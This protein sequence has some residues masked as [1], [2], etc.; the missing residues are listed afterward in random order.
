MEISRGTR[1]TMGIGG[2]KS[3]TYGSCGT[4]ST[5]LVTRMIRFAG[6][7]S[8]SMA[9]LYPCLFFSHVIFP[10][11][12]E[13]VCLIALWNL[14]EFAITAK[15]VNTELREVNGSNNRTDRN[16]QNPISDCLFF[17]STQKTTSLIWRIFLIL[18]VSSV[19]TSTLLFDKNNAG[20]SNRF[21]SPMGTK[22]YVSPK[23][24]PVN[25]K[26]VWVQASQHTNKNVSFSSSILFTY[27]RV[28]PRR[29]GT[30]K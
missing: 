3:S 11:I 6:K 8:Q 2:W 21:R 28:R 29:F 23:I 9:Y 17:D 19:F 1:F 10:D 27:L 12:S 4:R 30:T 22:N 13:I 7:G 14:S 18:A 25:F 5:G 20:L 26:I 16:E 15:I 24:L